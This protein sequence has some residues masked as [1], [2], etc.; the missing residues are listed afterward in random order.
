[1]VK[2]GVAYREYDVRVFLPQRRTEVRQEA[3][4]GREVME[5]KIF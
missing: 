2:F 1:V 4:R 5:L 3:H